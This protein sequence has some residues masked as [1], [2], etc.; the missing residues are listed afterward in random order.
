MSFH[1]N[2]KQANLYGTIAHVSQLFWIQSGTV[3]DNILFG[4]PMDK[5]RYQ[6]TIKACALDKDINNLSHGDLTEI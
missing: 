4:K 6:N 1:D 3:R 2:A 5:K